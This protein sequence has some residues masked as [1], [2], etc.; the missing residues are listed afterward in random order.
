MTLMETTR[1]IVLPS[2]EHIPRLGQGTWHMAENPLK[3]TEEVNALRLGI[4]L[5][6]TLIDTAEMYADGGAERVVGEAIKGRRDEIFLVS[7]VL[8]QNAT[9]HGTIA[10]CNRSL[11]RLGVD[12][13]DLYL[14]HWRG[15]V[16]L[17]ETVDAF[18]TLVGAGKIRNWGVSNFDV[19]DMQE[20]V[21][22]PNGANVATDQVLYNLARRGIEYDLMPLCQR[23]GL[24]VMA[25]SPIEQ[26]RVLHH[27]TLKTIAAR[28]GATPAQVALGWVLRQDGVCAIPQ[29]GKPEHVRENRGALD[30]RLTPQD[31]A[32]LDGSFPPPDRKQPLATH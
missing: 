31:L 8:P 29:S 32:E 14:L 30:V 27:V 25:Y 6:M 10:A 12:E 23:S 1:T 16:P 26:G 18:E 15:A 5:G 2:G 13:I 22:L 17:E 21:D 19:A 3:R 9:Q 7:K 4:D 28:L 24:P 20:L 11:A